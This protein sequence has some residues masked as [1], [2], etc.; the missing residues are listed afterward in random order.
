[1]STIHNGAILNTATILK[2]VMASAAE[3]EYAGLFENTRTAE[4]IQYILQQMGHQ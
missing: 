4:P 2:N 1:M 3:A